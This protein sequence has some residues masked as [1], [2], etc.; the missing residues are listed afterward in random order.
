[1]FE[2]AISKVERANKHI[3][4]LNDVLNVFRDTDLHS[5]WV[6]T[7]P[8][9]GKKFL[10]IATP[11]IP[12]AVPFILGDAIHNLR[13]ALDH[14]WWRATEWVGGTPTRWTQIP[15]RDSREN[16]ISAVNGGPIKAFGGD[17]IIN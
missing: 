13:A 4:D 15:F 8:G 17:K 6:E 11:S 1:M 16:V 3:R 10:R 5:L 14:V 2:G 12:E 7:D 9:T